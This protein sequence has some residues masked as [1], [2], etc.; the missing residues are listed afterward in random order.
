MKFLKLCRDILL[1]AFSPILDMIN[2][3]LICVYSGISTFSNYLDHQ[4]MTTYNPALFWLIVSVL[5]LGIISGILL[6][7]RA[8]KQ[9]SNG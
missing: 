6:L 5:I 7:I 3:Y 2:F 8:M 9:L 1:D 4:K